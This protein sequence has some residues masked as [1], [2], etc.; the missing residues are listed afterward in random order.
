[1]FSTG[2]VF[3]FRVISSESEICWDHFHTTKTS[4]V[5]WRLFRYRKRRIV[6]ILVISSIYVDSKTQIYWL[7]L[8]KWRRVSYSIY[9]IIE[10]FCTWRYSLQFRNHANR[11]Y[12]LFIITILNHDND[13]HLCN[14]PVSN[15]CAEHDLTERPLRCLTLELELQSD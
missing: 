9:F 6:S 12:Y 15:S 11:K 10:R 4:E 1:M 7:C 5:S 2:Y 14:F 13:D 3:F 8:V